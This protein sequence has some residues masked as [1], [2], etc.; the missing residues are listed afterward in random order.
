MNVCVTLS[1]IYGSWPRFNHSSIIGF[2]VHIHALS[3]EEFNILKPSGYFRRP[4][5]GG[6]WHI[7]LRWKNYPFQKSQ[8]K[9]PE[10]EKNCKD[11]TLFFS[12]IRCFFPI[13]NTKLN[14]TLSKIS[15][16]TRD[17]VGR[18]FGT[19]THKNRAFHI[20]KYN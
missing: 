6:K 20:L 1:E 5:E 14:L 4:P 10:K 12:I 18:S 19:A 2:N 11:V 8:K 15:I 3:T 17:C 13:S 7:L 16:K 9:S